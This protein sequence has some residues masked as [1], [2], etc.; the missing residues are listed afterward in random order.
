M[1]HRPLHARLSVLLVIPLVGL[2]LA[3]SASAFC[4]FYV[5][6]AD[7]DL[8]NEAS[9]VAIVRDGERTV[10]TMAN[11]YQ[12]ELTEFAL[13]VPVPVVLQEGQIPLPLQENAI[14]KS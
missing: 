4:G 1:S 7:A 11:D 6:K 3:S 5:A 12:G 2:L 8:F 9:E 10:L 14:R 13:V